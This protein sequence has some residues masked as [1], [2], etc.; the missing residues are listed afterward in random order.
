MSSIV[1]K[2]WRSV[3]CLLMVGLVATPT[4]AQQPPTPDSGVVMA[5]GIDLVNQYMFRGVRQNTTGIAVWPSA[6]LTARVL[7]SDGVVKR[8]N[9]TAGFWSSLQTGDTGSSGPIGKPWYE[10]RIS[11][12]WMECPRRRRDSGLRRDDESLQWRR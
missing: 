8:V 1:K 6:D 5:V 2:A 9:L 12:R 7:A 11:D 4:S 3:W 10:S